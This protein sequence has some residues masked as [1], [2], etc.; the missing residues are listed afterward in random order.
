M[1]TAVAQ[2]PKNFNQLRKYRAVQERFR[3]LYDIERVRLD[4]VYR[5][6]EDQFF[7]TRD[8]IDRILKMELPN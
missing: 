7:I 6:V 5:K 4:D 8:R 1:N 2:Q 3:Y